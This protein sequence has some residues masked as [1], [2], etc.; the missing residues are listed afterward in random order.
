MA[1]SAWLAVETDNDGE[2]RYF[3]TNRVNFDGYPNG[4]G[5]DL[6]KYWSDP[7]DAEALV[8]GNEIRGVDGDDVERYGEYLSNDLAID[9][10]IIDP[11]EVY[12]ELSLANDESN[13]EL[14]PEDNSYQYIYYDGKWYAYD[15]GDPIRI[16]I[17]ENKSQVTR[18]QLKNIIKKVI[19]ENFRK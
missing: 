13:T 8:E 6:V 3:T 5:A 16:P 9:A 18:R 14:Y 4:L 2:K 7:A 10:D 17:E 15:Y 19:E 1:T 12:R 11:R